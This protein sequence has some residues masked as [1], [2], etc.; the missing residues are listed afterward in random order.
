MRVSA[1]A[2]LHLG[3]LDLGGDLG[4]RFGSLGL[5]IDGFET[6]IEMRRAPRF[7]VRGA[8]PERVAAL[9]RRLTETH[10]CDGAV[11]VEVA[12]AIKPR[13]NSLIASDLFWASGDA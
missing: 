8:E 10:D 11:E 1:G 6:L 3:F 7:S 5:A 4:R 9:V 12:S 2:R 13:W